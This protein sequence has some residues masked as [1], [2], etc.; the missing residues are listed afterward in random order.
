M[1]ANTKALA[2]IGATTVVGTATNAVGMPLAVNADGSI[3]P[4]A[5]TAVLGTMLVAAFFVTRAIVKA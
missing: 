5:A 3:S 4:L 1:T 2:I